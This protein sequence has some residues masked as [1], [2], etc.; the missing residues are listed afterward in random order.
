M[1]PRKA[2]PLSGDPHVLHLDDGRGFR[3]GQFQATLLAEGLARRRI[4]QTAVVRPDS[5]VGARFAELG[6]QVVPYAFRGEWDWRAPAFL[7]DLVARRGVDLIHAHTAHAHAA[8]L[9]ALKRLRSRGDDAVRLVTTRRVDF[10]ISRSWFSH[11]KYTH[12]DQH[13]IAIS[14]GVADVL[15]EGGVDPSRIDI[16]P[17]GV[18]PPDPARVATREAAREAFGIGESE[19]AVVN[20]GA[21]TDHKG[22]R[23]LIEAAGP[24]V[25]ALP[26]VRFHILGEGELRADLEKHARETRVADFVRFHGHV[27]DARLKLAGFDLYVSSSHLEGMG[28]S[29]LDA[30]LSGLPVVAAA[31]GGVTDVVEHGVTGRLVPPRDS[32]ALAREILN[33]LEAPREATEAV[34]RAARVNAELNFSAE[35]MVEGTLAVYRRC[36]SRRR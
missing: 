4:R 27:P 6:L 12:P 11:R 25:R 7:A 28:T 24:V 34:V 10:R 8:G 16:V 13:F 30:M 32:A 35:G 9:R 26:E 21:L 2:A 14:Q 5:P 20:V 1:I 22:Q 19:I 23:Y 36:R 18:P 3:G 29:I 17:S 33:A 15:L 31:A